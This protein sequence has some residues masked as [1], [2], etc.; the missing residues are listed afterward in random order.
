MQAPAIVHVY[1]LNTLC[2]DLMRL[3]GLLRDFPNCTRTMFVWEVEL[4]WQEAHTQLSWS[5][6]FF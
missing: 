3:E 5:I 6:L 2:E 4:V 1:S